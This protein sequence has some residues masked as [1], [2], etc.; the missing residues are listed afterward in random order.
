[1]VGLTTHAKLDMDDEDEI[2]FNDRDEEP[3]NQL[4]EVKCCLIVHFKNQGAILFLAQNVHYVLCNCK[5]FRLVE[6]VGTHHKTTH[7]ANI[8]VGFGTAI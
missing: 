1:M 8:A 7:K 4:V 2:Y 3:C 5:P 6:D